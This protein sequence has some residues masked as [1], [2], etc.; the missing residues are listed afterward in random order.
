[1]ELH[2]AA[3]AVERTFHNLHVAEREYSNAR[4]RLNEAID[5]LCP[6]PSG[7]P[8]V[9][10]MPIPSEGWFP[11]KISLIKLLREHGAGLKEAKDAIDEWQ[12]KAQPRE[13]A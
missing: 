11:G 4:C 13:N 9:E 6:L 5:R 8:G 3:D 2:N 10:R 12:R 7:E 1:M